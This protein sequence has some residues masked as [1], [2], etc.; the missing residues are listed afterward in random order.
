MDRKGEKMRRYFGVSSRKLRVLLVLAIAVGGYH[1][2]G[3]GILFTGLV[4]F[5]LYELLM[6]PSRYRKFGPD[7]IQ[8]AVDQEW[9][10]FGRSYREDEVDPAGSPKVGR[11]D[12]C[13]CGSGV[14]YKRCCGRVSK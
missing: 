5:M 8:Q 7:Q 9:G 12:P 14:K 4:A 10:H 11:N 13:L 2:L 3:I 1:S 6:P